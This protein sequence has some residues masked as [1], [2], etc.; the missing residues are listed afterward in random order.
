MPVIQIKRGPGTTALAQGELGFN[1]NNYGLYIGTSS[2]NVI[3]GRPIKIVSQSEYDSAT[4]NDLKKKTIYF[5]KSTDSIVTQSTVDSSFT[6]LN[7]S[8]TNLSN[9]ISTHTTTLSDLSTNKQDNVTGGI[10]TVLTSNLTASRA[11]I[12][13]SSGKIAV[14]AVTTT[15][16]NYLNGVTSNINTQLTNKMPTGTNFVL[17]N[18]GTGGTDASTARSSL[19]LKCE[20]LWSGTFTSGNISFSASGYDF[21][22]VV[23]RPASSAGT[24]GFYVPIGDLTS[25][26]ALWQFNDESSYF[27]FYI[28]ISSGT[29]TFTYEA[30]SSGRIYKV[31]GVKIGA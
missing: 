8:I 28:K 23:G 10:S 2:G 21:L 24:E 27:E 25:T 16:L 4:D 20:Q 7:T 6:T 13:N 30:T 22:M 11:L 14:S 31:Y 18:G 26:N 5:I 17:T 1:T 19:G 9:T 29:V 3:V 15:E 12:S